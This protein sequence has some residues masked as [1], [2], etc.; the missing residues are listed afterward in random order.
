MPFSHTMLL[1]HTVQNLCLQIKVDT[2]YG[3]HCRRV[4]IY[5]AKHTQLLVQTVEVDIT[6]HNRFL[7]CS[8]VSSF[9]HNFTKSF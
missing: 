3:T 6:Q 7:S 1:A 2:A 9:L 4:F 8:W 5:S